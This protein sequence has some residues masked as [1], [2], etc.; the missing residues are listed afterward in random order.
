MPYF[1]CV[2]QRWSGGTRCSHH[3]V[4]RFGKLHVP[5][6]KGGAVMAANWHWALRLFTDGQFEVIGAWPDQGPATGQRIAIDLYNQGMER[7][8]AAAAES[9][10]LDALGN[11]RFRVGRSTTD[12]L[13]ESGAFGP[14]TRRAIRWTDAA[15]QHL[16]GRLSPRGAAAGPV[17]RSVRRRLHRPGIPAGRP[18]SAARSMGPQA[19]GTLWG[20]DPCRL[21][22]HEE[23]TRQM[24]RLGYQREELCGAART[25]RGRELMQRFKQLGHLVVLAVEIRERDTERISDQPCGSH[26]RLMN[27]QLVP[28][29]PRSTAG[30]INSDEYAHLL[31]RPAQ[32]LSSR[33]HSPPD[34]R[35]RWTPLCFH[36]TSLVTGA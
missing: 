9:S 5:L 2:S 13:A 14:R 4:V 6:L 10:I 19:A 18:R 35:V 29:D 12:K 36:V 31:L 1:F 33:A 25:L 21:P 24:C 15:G 11:D 17:C 7:I 16:Q 34:N 20:A 22:G 26:G 28:A 30:L 32:R 8:K 3:Q 23:E 27:T